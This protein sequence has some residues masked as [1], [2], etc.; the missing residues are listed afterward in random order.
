MAPIEYVPRKSDDET[1][2][3]KDL[4]TNMILIPI[5]GGGTLKRKIAI[6]QAGSEEQFM[7][8]IGA[9]RNILSEYELTTN[10]AN[11]S[12]TASQIKDCFAG[13]AR[14]D[15]Q[16][17]VT[18]ANTDEDTLGEELWE[19]TEEMLPENAADE[20]A[21]YLRSTKKPVKLTAKEWIKRIQVINSHMGLMSEEATEMSEQELVK[22]VIKP[23]IPRQVATKFEI[24]YRSG[25]SLKEV[26]RI[27]GLLL[28]DANESSNRRSLQQKSRRS[29]FADET[30]PAITETETEAT[31]RMVNSAIKAKTI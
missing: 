9:I 17:V 5:A 20:Q 6:Y 26:A 23:D 18:Q 29:T 2:K 12:N 8:T 15:F 27:L 7:E 14:A 28:K 4:G 10:A 11:I 3:E 31:M 22:Q 19:F 1:K 21:R 13:P 24:E 30:I 25:M 16:R